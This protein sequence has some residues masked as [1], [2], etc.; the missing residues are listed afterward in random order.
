M[1][2]LRTVR[3]PFVVLGP[4]DVAV[5]DRLKGLSPADEKV[6]R[7]VGDHLGSLPTI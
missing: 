7:L 3:A 1:G 5:R 4:S 2:D 6:L